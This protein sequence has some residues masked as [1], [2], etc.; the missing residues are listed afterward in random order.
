MVHRF[1]NY[2]IA[3]K[4]K[5]KTMILFPVFDKKKGE[6]YIKRYSDKEYFLIIKQKNAIKKQI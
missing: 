5:G 6:Y 3:K 2:Y 1:R 4:I